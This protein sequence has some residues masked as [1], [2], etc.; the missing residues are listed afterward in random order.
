M[1]IS[2]KAIGRIAASF[3]LLFLASCSENRVDIANESGLALE[4]VS[5]TASWGEIIWQGSLQDG[6]AKTI[7]FP[8][9]TDGALKLVVV[10]AEDDVREREFSYMTPSG[11]THEK[12]F[13]REDRIIE[14]TSEPAQLGPYQWF[15]G[16][17][18][19]P[20]KQTVTGWQ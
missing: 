14:I 15:C 9:R 10:F 13:I 4:D 18:P 7:C 2:L 20:W 1:T 11:D 12:V 17:F 3:L 8:S 19:G 16:V 6:K 5:L